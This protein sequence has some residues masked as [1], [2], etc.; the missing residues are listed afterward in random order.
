MMYSDH[1][2]RVDY[3]SMNMT[4]KCTR[5]GIEIN[6]EDEQR[7]DMMKRTQC[8]PPQRPVYR[9]IKT[10]DGEEHTVLMGYE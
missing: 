10:V 8:H 1:D 6:V 3:S 4:A 9:T 2:F 7:F 5:C